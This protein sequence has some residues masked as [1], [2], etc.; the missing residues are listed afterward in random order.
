M[1]DHALTLTLAIPALNESAIILSNIAE[2]ESWMAENLPEINFEILVVDDGSTDGMGELLNQAAEHNPRLRV[3]HH[4]RNLGR[5]RAIRTAME[6]SDGAW[7]IALD[8]D[9]SYSPEHIPAL[10]APLRNG[11]A[12]V[13]LA[14]PYH[15]QGSVENVPF[16]RA[17]LSRVGNRIL[18][19]SFESDIS[20]ATCVVRGY[21]REVMD[22]L[23]LVNDG[24][25]LHLEVLYKAEI[26]GFRIV[27]I[28]AKLVW[29]DRKR[30]QA[31]KRPFGWLRDNAF[32]KMRK[33]IFSHF[34]FNFITRPKLLFLGPI[35]LSL[36]VM[37]YGT[38]SLIASYLQRL[39]AG[40]TAPFRSTLIDGQ[41]TL[42]LTLAT[43][44]IS[45]VFFFFLFVASQAKQY[46]EEQYILSTRSHYLLKKLCRQ[47][48]AAK[49][50]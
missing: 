42:S 17:W 23:E 35:V 25:D 12:D 3:V 6:N 10:L 40:E 36:G 45:L 14:S 46:F 30:G 21:T 48:D 49:K 16:A 38:A 47:I 34:A 43:L 5:G 31:K 18:S 29:R 8:A 50:N 32:I 1:M 39:A 15:P 41:L 22:H 24:K 26:L 2:L 20:T 13:T 11:T 37:I 4:P 19:R 33:V 7:L 44:I 27:E 28:P 9:L